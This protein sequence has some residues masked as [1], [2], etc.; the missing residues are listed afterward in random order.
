[1]RSRSVKILALL[2]ALGGLVALASPAAA[3][4][5]LD[6]GLGAR[7]PIEK[8][9]DW[10]GDGWQRGGWGGGGGGWGGG[11]WGGGYGYGPRPRPWGYGYG[12]RP[13]PWGWGHH[14]WHGG[15]WGGGG[16]GPR[17]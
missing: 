17:W 8:I 2:A 7:A 10:D 13:R 3:F 1:M 12:W 9:D 15:G 11:G 14:H 6:R 16:W 5:G 4:P